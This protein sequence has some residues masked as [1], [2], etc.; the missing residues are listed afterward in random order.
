MVGA[1]VKRFSGLVGPKVA[2]AV[3]FCK[4]NSQPCGSFAS[5]GFK[6]YDRFIDL[7]TSAPCF[8]VSSCGF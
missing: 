3:S 5:K 4:E 1:K 7:G 6:F 8:S 2:E